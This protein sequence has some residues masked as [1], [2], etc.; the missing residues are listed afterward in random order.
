MNSARVSV[1]PLIYGLFKTNLPV[2]SGAKVI[3]PFTPSSIV[4]EPV[5]VPEFVL[6]I[7]SPVPFVVIVA[8]ALL[9]PILTVSESN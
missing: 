9:S 3:L 4:I 8:F 7:K 5:V 1:V 6:R 2:P